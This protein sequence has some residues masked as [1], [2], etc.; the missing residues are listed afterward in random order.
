MG[1]EYIRLSQA[2]H[3]IACRSLMQAESQA[4]AAMHSTPPYVKG[5]P[6]LNE[7]KICRVGGRHWQPKPL[8]ADTRHE[9]RETSRRAHPGRVV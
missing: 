3:R 4:A 5:F 2:F 6:C 9:K 1:I 7:R 8:A